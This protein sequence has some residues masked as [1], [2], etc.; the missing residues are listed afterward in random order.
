MARGVKS[1]KIQFYCDVDENGNI[2]DAIAGEMIIPERQYDYFFM[3]DS[4]DIPNNIDNYKVDTE[5][6][7][8]VLKGGE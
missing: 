3:L 8:L 1:V 4:W 2:I 6:R 7:N 5:T